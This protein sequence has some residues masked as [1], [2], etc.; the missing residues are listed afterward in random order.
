MYKEIIDFSS[1]Y[2]RFHTPGHS[3]RDI[4]G[5]IYVSAKYDITELSFSDNLQSPSGMIKDVEER[6]KRAYSSYRSLIVT[7]GASVAIQIALLIAKEMKGE[8][9]VLGKAHKSCYAF[10]SL[11]GLGIYEI[12]SAEE[13]VSAAE[14]GEY[15]F[16][17]TPDYF[18]RIVDIDR[19]LEKR[20]NG[21]AVI[22]DEAHGSHFAFS[23]LFPVSNA[24]RADITID[25][26]HKTLPVMTGGACLNVNGEYL[27]SLAEYFRAK[28]HTTSP[29][30]LTMESI[31][32]A[33]SVMSKDGERLYA[34]TFVKVK[35]FKE[36]LAP[37]YSFL[38]NADF[39]RVVIETPNAK[40]VAKYL[41]DKG[42]FIELS[43]DKEMTLI[44]T[45][46]NAEFLDAVAD[47]LLEYRDKYAAAEEVAEDE[48]GDGL[49]FSLS[50]AKRAVGRV[51]FVKIEDSVGK[52]SASDVAVY[53]PGTPMIRSGDIISKEAASAVL[54][55][56]ERIV[57]LVGENIAVR[58]LCEEN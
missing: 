13:A 29:S 51:K 8:L 28:I 10:A 49:N 40:R 56:R 39:S 7:S 21:A 52:V 18:G 55:N 14:R 58:E 32:H 41:E 3:G 37:K 45:P 57:G 24:S 36:K 26:L 11:V 15:I 4:D 22:V 50:S 54:T 44:V 46:Y 33:V 30:Y 19:I 43:T 16:V 6:L 20:R 25:S 12:S 47:E 5:R 27:S 31:D 38:D 53:P 1:T 48:A 23:R 9:Y 35:E 42:T 34:E 2:K 17:T